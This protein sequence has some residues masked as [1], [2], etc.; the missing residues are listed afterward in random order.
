MKPRHVP[1]RLRSICD[2]VVATPESR[3]AVLDVGTG[4]ILYLSRRS[5]R[6]PTSP[7]QPGPYG[8]ELDAWMALQTSE[9][10]RLP[11]LDS[12]ERRSLMRQFVRTLGDDRIRDRLWRLTERRVPYAGFRRGLSQHPWHEGRWLEFSRRYIRPVVM[13]W[14]EQEHLVLEAIGS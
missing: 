11:E 10:Q 1:V 2:A 14:L 4:E 9:Y 8:R 6:R 5:R 13:D 3:V 12:E 7:D